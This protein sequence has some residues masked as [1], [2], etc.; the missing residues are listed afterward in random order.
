MAKLFLDGVFTNASNS[1]SSVRITFPTGDNTFDSL[2][3]LMIGDI[4]F[5]AQNKWGPVINDISNLSDIST[6]AGSQDL[7][8]WISASTMCWKGTEPLA[9]SIE[10]YLI[11]YAK[12]LGLEAKL[13]NL[14]TPYTFKHLASSYK[15]SC[16]IC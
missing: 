2:V 15:N 4:T 10:F 3:G 13:K 7:F 11:N 8:S 9:I 6:L 12:N 1:P 5:G 16:L 14:D